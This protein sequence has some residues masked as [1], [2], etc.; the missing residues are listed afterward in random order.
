MART[1]SSR[2]TPEI[3]RIVAI[4]LCPGIVTSAWVFGEGVLLNVAVAAC[5]GIGCEAALLRL[6]DQPV[7][8]TLI[9][10]SALVTSLLIALALPPSTHPLLIAFAVGGALGLG[11]HVYGGLG[12]NP[13]NPAMV[14]YAL[15]LVSFPAQ[16]AAWPQ[17]EGGVDQVTGATALETFKHR[18]GATVSDIWT[19]ANGF[20][21]Y[22]VDGFESINAAIL[23]G[24]IGLVAM[25]IIDWRIPAGVLGTVT[26]LAA[27][28]YDGGSSASL[29]SP[30][31]HLTSGAIMLCAFFIATD[32][33]TCPTDARGRWL[34]GALVGALI[35]T[36]RSYANYPDGVAFAV[37]I[38]NAAT[39]LINR[40]EYRRV[41]AQ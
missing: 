9:D 5:L 30:A 17:F 33:V 27:V 32:P 22:G 13:F 18:G 29:G 15:L 16:L 25:R 14:G 1:V 41:V 8:P 20:G 39:P 26:L 34:F 6:R 21:R 19:A 38:A 37:L 4:A 23:V 31:F 3:M 40:L 7:A 2:S 24:G 28:T 10:G 35:F 12:A 11:K 36:L